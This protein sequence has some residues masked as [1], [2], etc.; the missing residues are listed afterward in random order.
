MNML[1]KKDE[2]LMNKSSISGG[3][4]ISTY[5]YICTYIQNSTKTTNN[6]A[7]YANHCM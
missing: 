2:D 6:L 5:T 7:A 1:R 3:F 4:H